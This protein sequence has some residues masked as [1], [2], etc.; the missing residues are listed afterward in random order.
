MT[1]TIKNQK[2]DFPISILMPVFNE[3]DIIEEVI[4]EWVDDVF[5][6][7]PEGS[8]FLI[9]EAASKDGTREILARMCQK[10]PFIHVTYNETRDGFAAA[11]RRLYSAAKCPWVFFT[12][13]DGQYIASEFWKL[14]KY[15]AHYDIIHGAK[16]ARQ[17]PFF[18]RLFS[19]LFN[20]WAVFLFQEDYLD[21][22]SA[23]RLMKTDVVKEILPQLTI[24]P[25]L[26]NAELLLRCE[27]ANYEIKQVY[28]M[29]RPRK[30]GGSRGLPTIRYFFEGF[31]AFRGLLQIKES[32]R[33]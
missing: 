8:E 28:I 10:Y 7:L 16:L 13:S 17:D 31:R 2:V 21:I 27:F 12:D 3:A 23:F 5:H 24:M 11:A 22:N 14:P 18:R 32:Y 29:H 30:H 20:K 19:L 33:K 15:T 25:S 9:D 6:F 4:E 26:L 1:R